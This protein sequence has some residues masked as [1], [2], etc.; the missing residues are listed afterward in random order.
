MTALTHAAHSLLQE[1]LAFAGANR[2]AD[3]ERPLVY[4]FA[5]WGDQLRSHR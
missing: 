4:I 5:S 1:R 3:T 2:C